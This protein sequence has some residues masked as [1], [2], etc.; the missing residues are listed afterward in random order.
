M[1]GRISEAI[2]NA[3]SPPTAPS[4]AT[5]TVV[6]S[7]ATGMVRWSGHVE[8]PV[9]GAYTFSTVTNNGVRLFLNGELLI[10]NWTAQGATT[11]T[12]A[13]IPLEAGVRYPITME[14]F[15]EAEAGPLRLQWAYPGQPRTVIPQSRLF[16]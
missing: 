1:G 2:A 15:G 8:A 11:S 13:D 4:A 12:S 5:A 10:D 9:T 3:L 14:Y 6:G 16:P 7:V